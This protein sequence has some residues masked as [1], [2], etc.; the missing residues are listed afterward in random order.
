M[1]MRGLRLVVLSESD[2]G[3]R[4]AEATMKRLTGGDV[5]KARRTRQDFVSFE[6]SY[7]A[8]LVTNYLPRVT[9]DD[10][11]V[12]RRIR[13]IPFDVV[14]TEDEQDHDLDEKLRLAADEII[15]WAVAGYRRYSQI[16]LAEPGEVKAATTK[17]QQ[18]SD[19]VG[20]FIAERCL[21]SPHMSAE[22][23]ELY[24]EFEA[25]GYPVT[26]SNGRRVRRGLGLL[27]EDDDYD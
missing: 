1:D 17:Y 10:P 20:R 6:P 13:V 7:T 2:R 23:G 11:A 8:I 25:R 3:R 16:G 12:W 14:F 5:I 24:Q 15:A 19:T 4:L 21:L 9:R 27:T 22:T 18:D 26:K